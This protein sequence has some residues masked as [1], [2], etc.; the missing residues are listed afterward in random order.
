MASLKAE[1]GVAE[2]SEPAVNTAL[3]D[4]TVDL[5]DADGAD[6]GEDR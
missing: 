3:G 2:L 4:F 1:Q 6:D 5:E